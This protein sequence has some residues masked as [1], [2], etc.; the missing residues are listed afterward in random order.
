MS[1]K[2]LAMKL[3]TCFLQVLA[4]LAVHS[5]VRTW[6]GF[7]LTFSSHRNRGYGLK[8]QTHFREQL[9]L[10]CPHISQ[11]LGWTLGRRPLAGQSPTPGGCLSGGREAT[12]NEGGF[13]S[14]PWSPSGFAKS[15]H[16]LIPVSSLALWSGLWP[17]DQPGAPRTSDLA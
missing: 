2:M 1:E 7:L 6:P 3:F 12:G 17:H 15:I 9:L 8:L 11:G 14:G 10:G 16:P 4:G 13:L 5:Q